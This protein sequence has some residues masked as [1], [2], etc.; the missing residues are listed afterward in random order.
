MLPLGLLFLLSGLIVNTVQAILFVTIRPF[1]KSFYRWID[2]FLAELL[3]L[4]LVW[5][6]DRWAGVEHTKNL[7][8]INLKDDGYW[9]RWYMHIWHWYI[10]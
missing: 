2:R 5:V 6:V 10:Y 1:S 3:W 7:L 4:Q 9:W 8:D